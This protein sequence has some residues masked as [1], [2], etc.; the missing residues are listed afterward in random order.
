M[1]E[2]P[3]DEVEKENI[4]VKKADFS[5]KKAHWTPQRTFSNISVF[6]LS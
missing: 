5:R 4:L 6:Q 1:S 2:F 3:T